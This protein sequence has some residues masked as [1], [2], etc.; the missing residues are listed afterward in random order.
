MFI[1]SFSLNAVA[2]AIMWI[3]S[4]FLFHFKFTS[5]GSDVINYYIH[6][7]ETFNTTVNPMEEIFPKLTSCIYKAYGRSGSRERYNGQCLISLNI[8]NEKIFIFL[9]M[10]YVFLGITLGIKLFHF[11][12]YLP[13]AGRVKWVIGNLTLTE[14]RS[15][16]LNDNF[17]AGDIFVLMRMRENICPSTYNLFIQ[18]LLK[19]FDFDRKGYAKEKHADILKKNVDEEDGLLTGNRLIA[20]NAKDFGKASL[21]YIRNNSKIS[22]KNNGNYYHRSNG[23]GDYQNHRRPGNGNARP[24]NEYH[25]DRES[26]DGSRISNEYQDVRKYSNNDHVEVEVEK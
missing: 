16:L 17:T 10:F 8:L 19:D 5:Y 15:K 23:W 14:K 20:Q 3:F 4:D 7:G 9:W 24:E 11:F 6:Y 1:F 13:K 26:E 21:A 18:L 2:L 12:S 25:H 22:R